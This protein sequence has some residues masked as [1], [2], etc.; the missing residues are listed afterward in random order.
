MLEILQLPILQDNYVYLVH[1]AESGQTAA[2]DP[3]LADP[4]LVALRQRQWRLDYIFNTHHHWDHVDGNL[5]LKRQTG[6]E[7]IAGQGDVGRIPGVDRGIGDGDLL[8]LGKHPIH[9]MVTP[10][11]T[12]HHV[13]YYFVGQ[14]WLF[15]GDTVFVMGC[16]RLF[17]GTAEQLWHS[18]QKIR[19]LPMTTRIYCAHEYT[20]NNAQFALALEPGNVALQVKV[21]D[22]QAWRAKKQPTVPSTMAEELATNP[23]FRE[24][25]LELQKNINML[26]K[27]PIQVFAQIRRL[28]DSF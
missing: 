26:G 20:L 25:S 12:L 17:E 28:K 6:C 14:Q 10:G 7:V 3:G 24:E 13:A 2:I 4:V 22:V 21:R 1:D 19:M 9:V 11:H 23:F 15:C 27:P 5:A 18:L 16:G 8:M